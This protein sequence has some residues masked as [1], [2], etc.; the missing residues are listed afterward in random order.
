MGLNYFWNIGHRNSLTTLHCSRG[1]ADA[2][3]FRV[4]FAAGY[5]RLSGIVLRCFGCVLVFRAGV[6]VFAVFD[7]IYSS[8]DFCDA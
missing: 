5:C 8:L 7:R 1:I 6:I 3:V 2:R 4:C